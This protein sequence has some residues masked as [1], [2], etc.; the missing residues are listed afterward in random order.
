MT[1][2]DKVKEKK[3]IITFLFN[4]GIL[5]LLMEDFDFSCDFLNEA[6]ETLER[7]N[8]SMDNDIA[9]SKKKSLMISFFM[10]FICVINLRC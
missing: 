4:M 2:D 9:V 3:I 10:T 7:E 1:I 8:E 6:I 5:Y